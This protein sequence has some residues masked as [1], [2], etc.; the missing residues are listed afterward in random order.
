L[1]GYLIPS[2]LSARQM[3]IYVPCKPKDLFC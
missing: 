1:G 2:H 3:I